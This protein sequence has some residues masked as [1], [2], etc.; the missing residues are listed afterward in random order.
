MLGAT[1]SKALTTQHRP[2]RLRFEGH[3]VGLAALIA[4]DLEPFALAASSS[5]L[6]IAKVGAARIAARLTTFRMTQSP[7]TII[8][9]LSF[10]KWEGTTALGASDFHVWHNCSPE[11]TNP[12][13]LL[14]V[15]F[16]PAD[17]SCTEI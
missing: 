13:G 11:K 16:T 5:A 4:D 14:L 3:V 12:E 8:I 7:L 1:R 17:E 2:A 15:Q 9:L 6:R 10:R